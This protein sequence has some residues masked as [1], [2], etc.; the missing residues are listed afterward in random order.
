MPCRDGRARQG[1]SGQTTRRKVAAALDEWLTRIEHSIK[2]S[3]AQ[4]WRNYAK[5]YVV[6]YIGERDVRAIDGGVCDALYGKLL[7]EGRIKARPKTAPKNRP[8]HVRRFSKGG[9]VQPCRP[10]RYDE[11]RSHRTHAEDDPLLGQPIESSKPIRQGTKNAD[12]KPFRAP[13]NAR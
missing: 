10:Y 4:N 3:M 12:R 5:Y 9:N 2:P 7:A 13:D 8:V 11:Y 6:P 1:P